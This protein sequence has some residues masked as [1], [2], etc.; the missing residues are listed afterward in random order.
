MTILEESDGRWR[1]SEIFSLSPHI[2]DNEPKEVQVKCL[3]EAGVVVREG[4]I[5]SAWTKAHI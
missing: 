2:I 1:E 4:E 3:V 5:V